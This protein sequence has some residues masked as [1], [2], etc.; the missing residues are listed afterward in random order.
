MFNIYIGNAIDPVE[1]LV[2]ETTTLRQAYAD[3]GLPLPSGSM[4]THNAVVLGNDALDKPIGTLGIAAGDYLTVSQKLK[5]ALEIRVRK[6]VPGNFT[7]V[8]KSKL[9]G[10]VMKYVPDHVLYE[11]D[12]DGNK[13]ATYVIST[14]KTG[15]GNV[16]NNGMTFRVGSD[17]DANLT[18]VVPMECSEEQVRAFVAGWQ[19]KAQACED[20]IMA[21]YAKVTEAMAEVRFED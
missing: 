12:E 19:R 7:V 5:S 2:S 13:N 3:A 4:I 18:L 1:V 21:E 14:A 20:K 17:N 11:K 8:V 10:K 16:S 6:N 15:S 9:T